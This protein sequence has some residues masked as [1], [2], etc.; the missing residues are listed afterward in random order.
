L[1]IIYVF[2]GQRDDQLQNCKSV[3]YTK[4]KKHSKLTTNQIITTELK[5]WKK[6]LG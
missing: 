5:E 3:T 1:S 4:D 6:K 2:S